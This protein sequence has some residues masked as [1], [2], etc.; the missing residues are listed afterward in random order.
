M[1]APSRLRARRAL[2]VV[3]V[4]AALI[5]GAGCDS[6]VK[7]S[8]SSASAGGTAQ[9]GG[10]LQV[11]TTTDL[12]PAAIFTNSN[13]AINLL[14]GQVYDSLIDYPDNSLTPKPSLAT[15]W[16]LAADGK[17]LTLNLRKGVTFHTGRTFTSKDVEFS[18][19]TWADPK[20]TVQFQRTAAAI[21]GFDTSKP[22]QITLKFDHPLSNILDLLDAMPIIDRATFSDLEKGTRYVGTGPFEFVSW[23]PQS[24]IV[25]KRN[26]HYW[27]DTPKLDGVDVHVIPDPQSLVSELRSGQLDMII[28]AG[29]RDL[30]TLSKTGSYNAIPFKGSERQTYVGVNVD[31]PYLKNYKLREAIAYA[32]DRKRIVDEVYRG[33]GYPIVLPWPTYSPAYNAKD[34]QKFAQNIAKAKALMQ[35]VGK[36]PTL[37]LEYSTANP[38]WEAIAQIVQAN[39]KEIGINVQLIPNENSTQIDKLIGGKF[40]ALWIQDH[41][42]AQYTPSTLAVTAYPFNADNNT[43][44]FVNKKYQN[45]ANAAW[46]TPSGQSKAALGA[47]AALNHDLLN[48]LFLIELSATYEE[49]ATA[50]YVHGVTWTKRSEPTLGGAWLD[51]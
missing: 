5:A 34:N 35:Q 30:Q 36:V 10:T 29:N 51:K 19:K 43:S 22:Y 31:N 9:S 38:N 4:V 25:L 48:S 27:R 14:I 12:V 18:I 13:D 8:Q 47:Y 28:G 26:P 40:P 2:S 45:D 21:T 6:A 50:G 11:G 20:W 44:H 24:E 3:A 7:H 32:V 1:K 46:E 39:L 15:S 41:A 16:H 49:T 37:P 33:V 17:S 42:Y 23:K